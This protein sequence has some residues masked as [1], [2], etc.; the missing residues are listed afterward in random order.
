MTLDVKGCV[1][2]M[3]V[4]DSKRARYIPQ[5]KHRI[6]VIASASILTSISRIPEGIDT[7]VE[8]VS[9]DFLNIIFCFRKGK[10]G[11]CL[12]VY[13]RRGLVYWICFDFDGIVLGG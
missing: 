12:E 11:A 13:P 8:K 4:F 3:T 10:S 2:T 5:Q 1:P 7:A 9:S 6:F